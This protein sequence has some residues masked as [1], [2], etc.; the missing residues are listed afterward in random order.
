MVQPKAS[1]KLMNNFSKIKKIKYDFV[2]Q[3]R[4]DLFFNKKLNLT[5]LN[6]KKLHLVDAQHL[7]K[8][9]QLY[10]IFFVSK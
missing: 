8:K 4:F 3:A 5:K 10:D 6:K 7:Q 9:N 1:L 2:V